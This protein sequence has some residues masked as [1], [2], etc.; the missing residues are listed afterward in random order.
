[1]GRASASSSRPRFA[2]LLGLAAALSLSGCIGNSVF[3][4]MNAAQP[5][6]SPFQEAL[7][8]KW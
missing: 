6:G 2:A 1:M 4:D 7:L 5:V 3:D 8:M